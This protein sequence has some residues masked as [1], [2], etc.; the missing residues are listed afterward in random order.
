MKTKR[1]KGSSML[2]VLFAL[3][4]IAS[5]ALNVAIISGCEIVKIGGL[6]GG[7]T[8]PPA[9]SAESAYL[10]EIA[11]V[12]KI[13]ETPDKTPGAMAF[14]IRQ[15]LSKVVT[16]NGAVLSPESFTKTCSVIRIAEDQEVFKSYHDFVGKIAGKKLIVL[17]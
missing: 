3:L 10:H 1:Q 5:V 15:R 14:D 16:Y 6:T 2:G 4:F 9:P 13:D 11:G 7:A 12:L 8:P 17:E